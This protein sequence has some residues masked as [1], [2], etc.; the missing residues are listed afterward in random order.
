MKRSTKI[1][2]ITLV[3]ILLFAVPLTFLFVTS[4]PYYTIHFGEDVLAELSQLALF[5]I[6]VAVL[7]LI[8]DLNLVIQSIRNRSN[9]QVHR[10]ETGEEAPK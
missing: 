10:F 8:Y 4:A 1:K 3:T 9:P 6:F 2:I 5:T 7:F